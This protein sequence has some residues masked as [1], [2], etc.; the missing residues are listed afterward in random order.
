M[1]KE[2]SQLNQVKTHLMNGKSIT[3]IDA[4]NLYGAFRLA[5]IIHIL[6]HKEGMA[7]VCDETE[8]FGRYSIET[9]K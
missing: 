8:G 3:P 7:I 4:L 6:R 2:Q 5:S 9:K 1:K